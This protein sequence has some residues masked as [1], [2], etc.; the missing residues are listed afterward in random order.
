M[1]KKQ[2]IEEILAGVRGDA[3]RIQDEHARVMKGVDLTIPDP[4][5]A[6]VDAIANARGL[7]R[8]PGPAHRPINRTLH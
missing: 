7:E 3:A 1:K 4:P 5:A 6:V 8:D 2:A